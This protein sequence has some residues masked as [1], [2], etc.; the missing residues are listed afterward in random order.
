MRKVD[1]NGNFEEKKIKNRLFSIE[2]ELQLRRNYIQASPLWDP[3]NDFVYGKGYRSLCG[4][5]W[6]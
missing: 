3:W 5:G 4:T 6:R 1:E 2:Y